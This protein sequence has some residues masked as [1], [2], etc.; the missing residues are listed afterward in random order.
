ME[1]IVIC[2]ACGKEYNFNETTESESLPENSYCAAT[3]GVCT[4]YKVISANLED[5]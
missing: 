1:L 5:N 3:D 2:V 4:I